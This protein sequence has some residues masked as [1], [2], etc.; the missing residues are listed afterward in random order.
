[1]NQSSNIIF[2]I[3][4]LL[5]S[6]MIGGYIPVIAQQK[7]IFNTS[8]ATAN[9][10]TD[11]AQ[12]ALQQAMILYQKGTATALF[13][14][15]QQLE[16]ALE[17]WQP[18]NVTQT[19][20]TLQWLSLIQIDL[21]NYQI[22]L[23][24]ANQLISLLPEL[25]QRDYW[26]APILEL[27]AQIYIKQ[28]KYQQALEAYESA[29]TIRQ[30][31]GNKAGEATVLNSL[32]LVYNQLGD[33]EQAE[34]YYNTA[35]SLI[36]DSEN[37]ANF[38][39]QGLVY[40]NLGLIANQQKDFE[41]A[42]TYYNQALTAWEQLPTTYLPRKQGIVGSLNNR[43]FAYA[44]LQQFQSAL[45]DYQQALEITENIGDRTKQA[46][47]LNNIGFLFLKQENLAQAEQFCSQA[48]QIRQDILD[49][50][51]E[52]LSLYCLALIQQQNGELEE[53]IQTIESAIKRIEEIRVSVSSQDLRTS[54]F[55]TQQDYYQLYIELLMQLNQQ[56]PNQNW[57]GK[58]LQVSEQAKARSLL[59]I[60]SN[61]G[62]DITTGIPPDLFQQNQQLQQQLIA[63]E[64]RRV[65]VLSQEHTEI[66]KQ[67]IETEINTLLQRY[68]QLQAKIK[69]NS[70]D[71][72]NLTQP[73]PL[74]LTEIQQQVL[75]ENTVLLEY[76]IGKKQS[77]LWIVTSNSIESHQLPE[78]E[79]IQNA[80]DSFRSAFILPRKR[81]RRKLT[82]DTGN[83]LSQMILPNLEKYKDKRL[84]IVADGALQYIPFAALPV[85]GNLLLDQSTVPLIVKHEMVTA[86]SAS[87]VNILRQNKDRNPAPKTLA[88]VAD[89][90]FGYNDERLQNH[91]LSS[92]PPL[93]PE[94]EKSARESGVLFNRLPFTEQEAEQILALFPNSETTKQFG[95]SAR[96][97]FIT[98]SALNQYRILHFATHGL[99]NSQT[100]EL[101]GLVL[102]L[103][104]ETGQPL[105]GFL[106]LY[107]IFNLQLS[108]D[109]G[110]LSACETGLGRQVQGEGLVGLTRGFMYAGIPRVVV[111]LWSVDDQA[112]A[113][114]MVKF[115]RRML[116]P[117]SH[118]SPSQAL[119]L[120]Q[121]EMW[122]QQQWK[123]PYYWA[124]F[125]LQGEWRS[126]DS[127]VTQNP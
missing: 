43:G 125:T 47:A 31:I 87:V 45:T 6:G 24:Y 60:L 35:L 84:L 51:K 86:P 8:E 63:A 27:T 12:Q 49:R 75:D 101:S 30:K 32:G 48:L 127:F 20:T 83:Q 73:Q 104:D 91:T 62:G 44:E 110:V 81:V 18:V 26:E 5:G 92:I 58:A 19:A 116:N 106:R 114:L 23:D 39:I 2:S 1:M 15:V 66:Q 117:N 126:P 88:V 38:S 67:E 111:S 33:F 82:E 74:T 13:Q 80:V 41:Q 64:E 54:F 59:E 17:L 105:N 52:P 16:I 78:Q 119:R 97:E 108:S 11:A 109:L 37:K 72:A 46:S 102:S 71:Y 122:Q 124:G 89:P 94:L 96:R 25:D 55:A 3:I 7:P 121:I 98:N 103:V 90:V 50:V 112:T 34:S 53:A 10:D 77:Y 76:A 57:D 99:L 40:N 42:I 118:N 29:Q 100:P 28:G 95:F 61:T 115:Y 14:A 65:K 22:A 93:T 69:I 56:Q 4:L 79:V 120:A 9:S 68:R 21:G 36:K 107:E 113:E 85:S 123:S 70:P